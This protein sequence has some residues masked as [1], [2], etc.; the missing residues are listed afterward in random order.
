M[1]SAHLLAASINNGGRCSRCSS[2]RQHLNTDAAAVPPFQHAL[3]SREIPDTVNMSVTCAVFTYRRS[4]TMCRSSNVLMHRPTSLADF[5]CSIDNNQQL[6]A[7]HMIYLVCQ[8]VTSLPVCVKLF[9][10]QHLSRL[11]KDFLH[12]SGS[13]SRLWRLLVSISKRDLFV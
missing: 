2:S 12:S 13:E 7:D 10:H 5:L 9:I 8:Y 1:E 4:D 3:T 6:T 11:C